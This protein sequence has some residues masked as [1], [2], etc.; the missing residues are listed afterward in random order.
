MFEDFLSILKIK[1]EFFSFFSH[2]FCQRCKHRLSDTSTFSPP[3]TKNLDFN[4]AMCFGIVHLKIAG[5]HSCE[6]SIVIALPDM[7]QN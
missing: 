3:H 6:R 5:R 7:V 1:F 4:A 2:L